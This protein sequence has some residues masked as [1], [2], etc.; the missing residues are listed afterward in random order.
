MTEWDSM[1]IVM[2]L[3]TALTSPRPIPPSPP[4]QDD[5]GKVTDMVSFYGTAFRVLNHPIHTDLRA[6]H[7]L[8]AV[9]SVPEPTDLIEDAM[10]LA[11]AVSDYYYNI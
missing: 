10:V 8:C 11:R 9:S 5:D 2:V 3:F 4:I 6:A 7:L 1:A